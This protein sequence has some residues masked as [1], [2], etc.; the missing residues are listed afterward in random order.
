MDGPSFSSDL[1]DMKSEDTSL[2][3]AL[4]ND[5]RK[6]PSPVGNRFWWCNDIIVLSEEA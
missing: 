5:L 1:N 6:S 2:I 4:L 3:N